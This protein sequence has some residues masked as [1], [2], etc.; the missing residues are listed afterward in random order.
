MISF[1][2]SQFPYF[3]QNWH[4][5]VTLYGLQNFNSK[6]SSHFLNEQ[7]L[8]EN[9]ENFI[10]KQFYKYFFYLFGNSTKPIL[11]KKVYSAFEK[12]Y[13]R[14]LHIS[15]QNLWNWT[16]HKKR[17][18]FEVPPYS[19]KYLCC[20]QFQFLYISQT[21]RFLQVCQI[22]RMKKRQFTENM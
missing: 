19:R 11:K 18:E 2:F 6:F 10:L 20:M 13:S 9:L 1:L 14:I 21:D 4:L 8:E 16:A 5:N 7:F 3:F 17:F 12:L 22:K 15:Y